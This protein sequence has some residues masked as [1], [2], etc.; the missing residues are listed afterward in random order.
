[1]PTDTTWYPRMGDIPGLDYRTPDGLDRTTLPGWD[2][3]PTFHSFEFDGRK[4]TSVNWEHGRGQSSSWSPAKELAYDSREDLT[5]EEALDRLWRGLELPGTPSDYHFLIQE[6]A[7]VLQRRR[8]SQPQ[9][10]EQT[11]ALWWLNIRLIEAAPVAIT[12][13]Y[14]KGDESEF[15]AASAFRELVTL[16]MNE[17][18]VQDARRVAE[19]AGRFSQG[20]DDFHARISALE[21]EDAL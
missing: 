18:Y 8:R 5:P 11:E 2:E 20:L 17:G 21:A 14:P 1:M 7:G 6:T 16:Y 15:Y 13:E 19:I 10:A 12:S 3:T 4:L 9:F